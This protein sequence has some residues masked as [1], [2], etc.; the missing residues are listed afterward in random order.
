MSRIPGPYAA[1]ASQMQEIQYSQRPTCPVRALNNGQF[2]GEYVP[3]PDTDVSFE[4][5]DEGDEAANGQ[6]R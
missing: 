3:H 4:Q 2:E 6:A 1:Q 5:G